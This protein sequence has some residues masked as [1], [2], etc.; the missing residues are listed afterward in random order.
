MNTILS[1]PAHVFVLT[2]GK[3]EWTLEDKNGKS[4]PTKVGLGSTAEKDQDFEYTVSFMLVILI[5]LLK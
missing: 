5:S 2:R 1:A 3:T 4:V